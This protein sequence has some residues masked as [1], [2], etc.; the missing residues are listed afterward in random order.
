MVLLL[1]LH[2]N[3]NKCIKLLSKLD[4]CVTYIGQALQVTFPRYLR[5]TEH[6]RRFYYFIEDLFLIINFI[7]A[8]D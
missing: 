8:V 5:S 6:L 3:H 1:L 4:N 2:H 7:F